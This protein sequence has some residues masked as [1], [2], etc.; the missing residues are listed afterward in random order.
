[1]KLVSLLG[2]IMLFFSSC[3]KIMEYYSINNST[4]P[5]SF[6]CRIK[7][8]AST[9][10]E[11]VN[12]TN[13][14]YDIK[15]NPV[16]IT[17]FAEWLPNGK[18]TEKLKFDT[19]GRLT[20]HQPFIE[21]G[22]WRKYVYEGE[23]RTPLRDTATDFLGKKYVESFKSDAAGR[24]IE[25]EIRWI[26]SPPDL[27]DDFMFETEVHRYY[28]DV[29]GNRQVN[30]FDYP[31]HKTLRYTDKPSLYSLHSAWQIIH[32]DFSKNS[33]ANISSYNENGLPLTFKQDEF[34]YWQPFLDLKQ[35][36]VVEYTCMTN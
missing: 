4:A 8:Y 20:M 13:F 5:A 18:A 26:Y 9:Y 30:P 31:W 16:Q 24:I 22:N 33:I 28:Y 12:R 35:N 27:E 17:Y 19:L 21:M 14:Q 36:S 3:Q 11:S 1:M 29:H 6:N 7:S 32:R 25:E 23:S 15:G 34:A 10:F 2:M